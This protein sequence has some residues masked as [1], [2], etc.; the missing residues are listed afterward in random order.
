MGES[1]RKNRAGWGRAF[2]WGLWQVTAQPQLPRDPK[3][4]NRHNGVPP[5]P[6]P[7][8]AEDWRPHS[9]TTSPV[10]PKGT[11][12]Q[13]GGG[14]GPGPKSPKPAWRTN[15]PNYISCWAVTTMRP[16]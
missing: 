13:R 12:A 7:G 9:W 5:T 16:P 1:R 4:K 6:V 3:T 10:G 2:A 8:S 14:P 15:T 11:E